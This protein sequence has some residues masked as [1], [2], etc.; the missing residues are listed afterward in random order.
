M[1]T[2]NAMR[3]QLRIMEER[4]EPRRPHWPGEVAIGLV[5]LLGVIV[6]AAEMHLLPTY[7]ADDAGSSF[8]KAN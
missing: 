8:F 4:G 6:A 1:S 7:S 2:V 3:R 5:V